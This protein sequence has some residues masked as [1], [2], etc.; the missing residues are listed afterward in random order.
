MG[1]L[2][3]ATHGPMNDNICIQQRQLIVFM[4]DLQ[5]SS[6]QTISS[7]ITKLWLYDTQI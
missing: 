5:R 7:I 6:K 3:A 2:L 4:N 1:T